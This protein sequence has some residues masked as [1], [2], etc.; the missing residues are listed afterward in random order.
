MSLL[1]FVTGASALLR[2][3]GHHHAGGL[4]KHEELL[5]AVSERVH[6]HAGVGTGMAATFTH[7]TA[8]W[9][10]IGMG[11]PRQT[12]TVIFDTGS[13]NLI[14]PAS[15]CD[16]AACKRHKMYDPKTSTSSKQIQD[17]G[18][19]PSA[20]VEMGDGK[21]TI[22]FGTGE[23]EGNFY[24]DQFCLGDACTTARFVGATRETDQ[25]FMSTEFDGILGLGFSDLSMGPSFN[26]VED[27]KNSGALPKNQFSLYLSDEGESE[28]SFGGYKQEQILSQVL[29]A[30]VNKQ[31][32]WQVAIDDVTFDNAPTGLCG[33]EG[34]QVAVD[35]GTS[36]LAG[37]T[38]IMEA[39]DE[40]LDVKS[41]C[42]NFDQLP[43]LG[44]SI[45]GQVLN[46]RPADYVDR[47]ED[48][49]S[50]ALMTLD[51]PPPKGPLFIFGDP[52]LRRFVTIYDMD[53]PSVG[54]AVAKHSD[55]TSVDVG[56]LIAQA[57]VGAPHSAPAPPA[58][59]PEEKAEAAIGEDN[60]AA[61]EAM[62][63]PADLES[64]SPAASDDISVSDPAAEIASL[65]G[66]SDDSAVK[67]M[68]D[69]F[70]K[71]GADGTAGFLQK[72]KKKP[73]PHNNKKMGL[74]S[75]KLYKVKQHQH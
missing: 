25:P 34:C 8:Y 16:S 59:S 42:S 7:K 52:F 13:G 73:A 22:T 68:A 53:G 26:I 64:D 33:A 3:T 11:S 49:C 58:Q 31:S 66:G 56:S 40:K 18:G 9:G 35:T 2:P 23:V 37:P 20:G 29:W 14:L 72:D 43:M 30:P 19:N 6:H 21:A 47:T 62:S 32:Y 57:R 38:E 39:L 55:V 61:K 5:F 27:L 71:D 44:F 70:K 74:I 67:K 4:A 51:V 12:F 24:E 45:N 1:F 15:D 75:I 48:G 46:L 50:T 69:N 10:E 63:D 65:L 17:P 41:D 28:I 60:V 36:L 54:F